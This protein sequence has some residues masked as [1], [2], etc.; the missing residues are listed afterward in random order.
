[1]RHALAED[2][3]SQS[4]FDGLG[5]LVVLPVAQQPSD[6]AQLAALGC[7]LFEEIGP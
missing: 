3:R 7:E 5:R 4:L 6:L 1:V 2:R